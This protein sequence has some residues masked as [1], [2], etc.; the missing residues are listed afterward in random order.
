[1]RNVIVH[2]VCTQNVGDDLFFHILKERY[3]HTRFVMFAPDVYKHI[4]GKQKG[5]VIISESDFLYRSTSF[6]GRLFRLPS[7][8]L[9]YAYLLL[10]Y[11]PK[12]FLFIGGSLFMEGKSNIATVISGIRKMSPLSP[13]LKIA[14]IGANYGP[15][16]TELWKNKVET[17]I[18][19]TDDVC[20]RDRMSYEEFSN[21]THVRW[22]NDIVIHLQADSSYKKE[23]IV[24]VNVRSVDN[25]PS[26]KAFKEKYINKVKELVELFQCKG[27]SIRL[28]SFCK[29]YGDNEITDELY[30]SLSNKVG[31]EKYFYQGNLKMFIDLISNAEYM[32]G[33]RFH[34]IILG[35]LFKQKVLPISYSLKTENMLRTYDLWNSIYDFSKFCSS[36]TDQ[37][38]E[39]FIEDISFDKN[40]NLMFSYLDTLL[41]DK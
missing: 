12:I 35:L 22:A 9:L 16:K 23:K 36:D 21:M 11:Q 10:K 39:H 38:L 2:G 24:C 34:A 28:L 31:V 26:L 15:Y 20:F 40:K 6:V 8:T 14:V 1:M 19:L 32:I 5:W 37:L 27:Y 18:K 41:I 25:C 3:P 4:L 30:N 29:A 17:A 13:N 33:T 7:I